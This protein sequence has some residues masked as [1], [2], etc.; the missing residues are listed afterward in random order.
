MKK[1]ITKSKRCDLL[2]NGAAW[3]ASAFYLFS[4]T[5]CFSKEAAAKS[6]LYSYRHGFSGFAAKLTESQAQELAGTSK[7]F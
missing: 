3:C 5:Y 7:S 1:F 4:Q 6:I 2:P